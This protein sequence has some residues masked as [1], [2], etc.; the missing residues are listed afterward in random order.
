[1]GNPQRPDTNG[2]TT[3][4]LGIFVLSVR[5]KTLRLRSETVPYSYDRLSR[6]SAGRGPSPGGGY[7]S[8][9]THAYDGSGNLTDKTGSGPTA[10]VT[11]DQ[12]TN[13]A[14]GLDYAKNRYYSSIL[15]RFLSADPSKSADPT[16]PRTW[17]QYTYVN[18]DPV[19]F[20]DPSGQCPE[21]GFC[22]TPG[23]PTPSSG[24]SGLFGGDAGNKGP[25]NDPNGKKPV[26]SGMNWASFEAFLKAAEAT[27]CKG[28]PDGMVVSL[29]AGL[30]AAI[31][32]TGSG[33]AVFNF[34]TGQIS[35]F[36]ALNFQGG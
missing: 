35:V 29:S 13:G 17:N 18:G 22:W 28:L 20:N 15:G 31:G 9:E 25:W 36:G 1:M 21:V 5:Q 16:D 2:T 10:H 14:V 23:D 8:I 24:V 6:L 27:T 26:A 4:A 11:V 7:C 32:A 30:A 19:N 34:N 3:R 33:E 12:L